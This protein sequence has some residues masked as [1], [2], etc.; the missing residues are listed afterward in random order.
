MRLAFL[1]FLL[2]LS[3]SYSYARRF[4]LTLLYYRTN[5]QMMKA[6]LSLAARLTQTMQRPSLGDLEGNKKNA[7]RHLHITLYFIFLPSVRTNLKFWSNLMFGFKRKLMLKLKRN[8]MYWDKTPIKIT[9]LAQYFCNMFIFLYI[10]YCW[11]YSK[12]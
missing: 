1:L 9:A 10:L 12:I 8:Y 5:C 4:S 3:T 2:F 11:E 6:I 7:N